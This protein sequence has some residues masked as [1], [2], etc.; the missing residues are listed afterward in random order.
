MQKGGPLLYCSNCKKLTNCTSVRLREANEDNTRQLHYKYHQDIKWYRRARKCGVCQEIFV[1]AEINEKFLEELISLRQRLRDRRTSV[2]SSVRNTNQWIE[3]PEKVSKEFVQN[4]LRNI[5]W[6][7]THSSGCPVRAPRH[8]DRVYFDNYHGWVIDFG[9]NTFLV[10]KAIARCAKRI[11]DFLDS[12]SLGDIPSVEELK[13]G[14]QYAISG[15]VSNYNGDEYDSFYPINNGEMVF[16][17]QAIDVN[18]AISFFLDKIGVEK[19][20][21]DIKNLT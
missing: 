1:T 6:W 12:V 3:Y 20:I 9:A 10:G 11:K 15:A 21:K 8:A 18:D 14:L 13:F 19:I 16:G 7:L 5:C 17:A 4:F 2:V